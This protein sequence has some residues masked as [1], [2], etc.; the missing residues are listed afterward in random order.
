[1]IVEAEIATRFCTGHVRRIEGDRV[2]V[3]LKD[4]DIVARW[5]IGLHRPAPGDEVLVARQE[6]QN[7]VIGI[8]RI[9]AGSELLAPGPLRLRSAGAL[10]LVSASEARFAAF[11]VSIEASV[12]RVVARSITEHFGKARRW[13]RECFQVRAGRMRADVSGTCET[14]AGRIVQRADGSVKID[15]DSI[16]LG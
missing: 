3:T 1:M 2:V 8:L 13:V 5:A 7:F 9:V 16:D 12:I 11:R 4:M 6:D 15:G 10:D 14:R